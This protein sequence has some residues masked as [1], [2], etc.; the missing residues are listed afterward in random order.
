LATTGVSGLSLEVIRGREVG[1]VFALRPGP[2]LLGNALGGSP[3]ID[4]SAQEGDSPRRMAPRQAQL[5]LANGS[6]SLRDLESPGG[7]FVNRQRLLPGQERRLEP[8]DVIQVGPVQLRVVSG[9]EASPPSQAPQPSP[10]PRTFRGVGMPM[11]FTLAS[12]ATCRSWD[13]FL[14]VSAQN[15]SALREELTS[16][17]LAAYLRSIGRDDIRPSPPPRGDDERLDDW[18][19]R[20]PTTRPAKPDL[21]VHPEVVR[22]RALPGGGTTRARFVITNTGYRLLRSTV[23]VEPA[24][25]AWVRLPPEY[26]REPFNTAETKDVSFE[27]V[28]PEALAA[29]MTC[30]LVVESN[31]GS[32]RVEVR[33]EPAVKAEG[34]PDAAV[35]S[36]QV[37]T[38]SLA[39]QVERLSPAS[40]ILRAAAILGGLRLALVAGDRLTGA[41]VEGPRPS[42]AGAAVLLALA[43]G[44]A[45]AWF[46]GRRGEPRDVPTAAFTGAFA[47]VLAAALAVA[48]SRAVEPLFGGLLASWPVACVFWA[49]AGAGLAGLST[50]LLPYNA[51]KGGTS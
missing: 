34:L 3:G 51:S 27:V 47:G 2:N 16:G 30:S 9:T 28:I 18:L 5:N 46:A 29:P 14:T 45:A 13:D 32:R 38:S 6:A 40:R 39:E 15:W 11:P 22:V 17:R 48:V 50:I 37:A 33:V 21:E 4:L 20:L 19:G 31:G 1:R 42:L 12:G 36:G 25:A 10:P 7:T 26:S 44:I 43:G 24:S 23:R 8:G 35:G 41:S 49:L